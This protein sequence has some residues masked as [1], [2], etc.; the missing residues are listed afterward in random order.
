MESGKIA[1]EIDPRLN[2]KYEFNG[3]GKNNNIEK[4]AFYVKC[5]ILSEVRTVLSPVNKNFVWTGGPS[6]EGERLLF[7]YE[8]IKVLFFQNDP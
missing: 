3:A 1:L 6:Y 5:V 2:I 4:L 8:F 7:H